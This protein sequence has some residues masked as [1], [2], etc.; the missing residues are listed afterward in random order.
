MKRTPLVPLVLSSVTL[1][2]LVFL[3]WEIIQRNFFS[4]LDLATLHFLYITRGLIL[5]AVL[6]VWAIWY[7]LK[8]RRRYEKQERALQERLFQ[9]EKMAALGTLT[10]GTAH[11]INNPIGIMLSRIEL[12]KEKALENGKDSGGLVEDLQVLHR[13]ASRV[14]AITQGLLAFS[15]R[16]PK[17][18]SRVSLS[19]VVE[20]ALLLAKEEIA[21]R[22][23]EV[24]MHLSRHL[25]PVLGSFNQL[26]SVILNL[27]SNACEAM[28]GNLSAPGSA[29]HGA[30]IA[31]AAWPAE[32]G[33]RIC[34]LD[35]GPGISPENARR[36]FDPFFTTKSKG[37]GLGLSVS[38]GIVESHG[39]D[40][41][42]N[43]E[44]FRCAS[45]ETCPSAALCSGNGSRESLHGACFLVRLPAA[46]SGEVARASF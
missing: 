26:E 7:I 35:N 6:A 43:P 28:D 1:T 3:V 44:S 24:K 25:P 10:G 40:L 34:V 12:M 27:L 45:R 23:I 20:E 11:E 22:G 42:L 8:F 14:A 9:V 32:D 39:G 30:R 16:A 41:S 15:R 13:H 17:E 19:G 2:A 37:T 31:I 33:I 36:I 4:G 5:G 29:R 21:R 46:I 38:Y 18:F